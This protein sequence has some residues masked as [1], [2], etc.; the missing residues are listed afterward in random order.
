[1][2]VDGLKFG[3]GFYL[4]MVVVLVAGTA[5]ICLAV[6]LFEFFSLPRRSGQ[7]EE[8]VPKGVEGKQRSTSAPR[9]DN[10]I[11]C[12]SFSSVI[13]WKDRE[14]RTQPRHRDGVR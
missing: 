5:T 4:G 1:M 7:R 13:E 14:D 11:P 10:I 6:W 2:F 12:F 9:E 3:I 8:R